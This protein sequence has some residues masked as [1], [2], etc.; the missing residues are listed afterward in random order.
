MLIE[1]LLMMGDEKHH[2]ND[3]DTWKILQYIVIRSESTIQQHY[4]SEEKDF[5]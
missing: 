2:R 3:D 5:R 1:M 4:N